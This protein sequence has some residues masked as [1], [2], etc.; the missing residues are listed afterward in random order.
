MGNSL[1]GGGGGDTTTTGGG[2]SAITV[3]PLTPLM[4]PG[5]HYICKFS[6]L[7]EDLMARFVATLET[8]ET[9]E[10]TFVVDKPKVEIN[11]FLLTTFPLNNDKWTGI[12]TSLASY[13]EQHIVLHPFENNNMDFIIKVTDSY[14]GEYSLSMIDASMPVN[15]FGKKSTM[16]IFEED[17]PRVTITTTSKI[18]Q[19]NQYD[20]T[21]GFPMLLVTNEISLETLFSVVPSVV[22]ADSALYVSRGS[23]MID[24]NKRLFETLT[25]DYTVQSSTNGY[26]VSAANPT[27]PATL[28]ASN[29]TFAGEQFGVSAQSVTPRTLANV[30]KLTPYNKAFNNTGYFVLPSEGTTLSK[31]NRYDLYVHKLDAN[32]T[33]HATF[34][35]VVNKGMEELKKSQINILVSTAMPAALT[36]WKRVGSTNFY[37]TFDVSTSGP[38]FKKLNFAIGTEATSDLVLSG[39]N[40]KFQSYYKPTTIKSPPLTSNKAR[41]DLGTGTFLSLDT[42]DKNN[43]YLS[44]DQ[45]KLIVFNK[46]DVVINYYIKQMLG[47][48]NIH[49]VYPLDTAETE[50]GSDNFGT[51]VARMRLGR[52]VLISNSPDRVTKGDD[53]IEI[54][55]VRRITV[56]GEKE[57][58]SYLNLMY[59]NDG[60]KFSYEDNTNITMHEQRLFNWVS[61]YFLIRA[62]GQVLGVNPKYSNDK[63]T[64]F[65]SLTSIDSTLLTSLKAFV[66]K[67]QLNTVI[68]YQENNETKYLFNPNSFTYAADKLTKKSDNFV[69]GLK[70]STDYSAA[71]IVRK[72]RT[73]NVF[74]G[75]STLNTKMEH[76]IELPITGN[77]SGSSICITKGSIYAKYNPF[78]LPT[79]IVVFYVEIGDIFKILGLCSDIKFS[80]LTVDFLLVMRCATSNTFNMHTKLGEYIK[81]KYASPNAVRVDTFDEFIVLTN[82][83]RPS[84]RLTFTSNEGAMTYGKYT[85]N[86][87]DMVPAEIPE[88]VYYITS[89]GMKGD[90]ENLVEYDQFVREIRIDSYEMMTYEIKDSHRMQ[91]HNGRLA[92]FIVDKGEDNDIV[93]MASNIL[94]LT[95]TVVVIYNNS[96]SGC[97]EKLKKLTN[98]TVVLMEVGSAIVMH[99]TPVTLSGSIVKFSLSEINVPDKTILNAVEIGSPFKDHSNNVMCYKAFYTDGLTFLPDVQILNAYVDYSDIDQRVMAYYIDNLAERSSQNRTIVYVKNVPL[100]GPR[101]KKLKKYGTTNFYTS[102]YTT[103]VSGRHTFEMDTLYA[104]FGVNAEDKILDI[105][106]KNVES[107]IDSAFVYA[108]DITPEIHPLPFTHTTETF[109]ECSAKTLWLDIATDTPEM[110]NKNK[111]LILNH[112]D[113]KQLFSLRKR[114]QFVDDDSVYT[115]ILYTGDKILSTNAQQLGYNV[116]SSQPTN[117]DLSVNNTIT[118]KQGSDPK[119]Y[120]TLVE[121]SSVLGNM[122]I[123]GSLADGF[124][125]GIYVEEDTNNEFNLFIMKTP[126]EIDIL[127]AA[128][129]PPPQS[130]IVMPPAKPSQIFLVDLSGITGA[131]NSDLGKKLEEYLDKNNIP[132]IIFYSTTNRVVKHLNTSVVYRYSLPNGNFVYYNQSSAERVLYG[133]ASVVVGG[134][135]RPLTISVTWRTSPNDN[136]MVTRHW[137]VVPYK[138]VPVYQLFYE[139]HLTDIVVGLVGNRPKVMPNS[140][141]CASVTYETYPYLFEVLTPAHLQSNMVWLIHSKDPGVH[142]SLVYGWGMPRE[143][144]GNVTILS[145]HGVPYTNDKSI[146]KYTLKYGGKDFVVSNTKPADIVFSNDNISGVGSRPSKFVFDYYY[147]DITTTDTPVYKPDMLELLSMYY[148]VVLAKPN[149]TNV[150]HFSSMYPTVYEYSLNGAFDSTAI[151]S[152]LSKEGN[153]LFS[154]HADAVGELNASTNYTL[155]FGGSALQTEVP[156]LDTLDFSPFKIYGFDSVR[157]AFEKFKNKVVMVLSTKSPTLFIALSI[158]LRAYARKFICIHKAIFEYDKISDKFAAFQLESMIQ[159]YNYMYLVHGTGFNLDEDGPVY[160]E[161]QTGPPTTTKWGNEQFT[162]VISN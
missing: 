145:S 53:Y 42:V 157:G 85:L 156:H 149:R 152:V 108:A 84:S 151:S 97:K 4:E 82:A 71:S 119:Y 30:L 77:F 129:P 35:Y 25:K 93:E 137:N 64:N 109:P 162:Y 121:S 20:A 43:Q 138:K 147:K 69:I 102:V 15:T 39:D 106:L 16:K 79:S 114:C 32:S 29:I 11:N 59:D 133:G 78:L 26:L 50:M 136:V 63:M 18:F 58:K 47:F 103:A 6:D 22:K 128:P 41:F 107:S 28:S 75:V 123:K 127:T 91:T 150:G 112:P 31:Q 95:K 135:G 134:G 142:V 146:W 62:M 40:F 73:F 74:P 51:S 44:S 158:V 115:T 23:G 46:F 89:S 99:N 21:V 37:A 8:I 52:C 148:H 104:V 38:L 17:K 143:K 3:K 139:H 65:M 124:S 105:C 122:M 9:F 12:S 13:D 1:S 27:Y 94:N 76:K 14:T 118:F 131:L 86:C 98:N 72:G 36:N 10:F 132:S 111:I 57:G 161:D 49:V 153:Y 144:F 87:L 56:D 34:L 70:D 33:N 48:K 60:V 5:V 92:F 101:F 96:G 24:N 120:Y 68:T 54:T 116:Y 88:N 66:A 126:A 155:H 80:E 83:I 2:G 67:N 125:K 7:S 19:K 117:I 154:R 113:S 140:F 110:K 100:D 90:Q 55:G 130:E 160:D 141:F 45:D 81:L 61:G 159:R